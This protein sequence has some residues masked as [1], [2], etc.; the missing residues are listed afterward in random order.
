MRQYLV[1]AAVVIAVTAC[2]SSQSTTD[3][4]TGGGGSAFASVTIQDLSFSPSTV[5]ISAGT[6]VTWTNNGPSAHTATSDS[7]LWNSGQLSGPSGGDAYGGGGSGGNYR[8]TFASAG[9]FT[10]HCA[11]HTQ[12]TGTITVT[13]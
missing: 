2:G 1:A 8:H 6:T 4:N 11:N 13:P 10:Y 9:T 5:T 3:S 12:M 7:G